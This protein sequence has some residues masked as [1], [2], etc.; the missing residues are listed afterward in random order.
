MR[1]NICHGQAWLR[2][3]HSHGGK[4]IFIAVLTVVAY[5]VEGSDVNVDCFC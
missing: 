4:V 3:R 2:T 1:V 5:T